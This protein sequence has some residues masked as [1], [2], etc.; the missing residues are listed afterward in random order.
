MEQI[1]QAESLD[2]VKHILGEPLEDE[3]SQLS[4]GT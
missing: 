3:S 4:S 2:Q 1:R